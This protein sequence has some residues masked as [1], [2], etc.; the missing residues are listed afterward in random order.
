MSYGCYVA[1]QN[2]RRA[3]KQI[4]EDSIYILQRLFAAGLVSNL[5][6]VSGISYGAALLVPSGSRDGKHPLVRKNEEWY[7]QEKAYNRTTLHIKD[8]K[9]QSTSRTT[10]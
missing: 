6:L 7:D 1:S 4:A 9:K 10:I 5:R 8:T 3:A 2:D